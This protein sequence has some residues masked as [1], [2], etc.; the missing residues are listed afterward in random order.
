MHTRQP[1]APLVT[2]HVYLEEHDVLA[3]VSMK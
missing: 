2:H 1:G 3:D